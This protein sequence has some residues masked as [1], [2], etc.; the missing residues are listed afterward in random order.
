[1]RWTAKIKDQNYCVYMSDFGTMYLPECASAQ[2][3]AVKLTKAGRPSKR[4]AAGRKWLRYEEACNK[5]AAEAY[6]AG[7]EQSPPGLKWAD[8]EK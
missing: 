8:F 2:F 1:M 6:C 3:H 4:Y 5:I 7:A